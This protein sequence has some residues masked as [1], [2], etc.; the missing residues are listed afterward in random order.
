V[1]H[2]ADDGVDGSVAVRRH[3][4]GHRNLDRSRC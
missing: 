4:L 2:G 3:A 1:G